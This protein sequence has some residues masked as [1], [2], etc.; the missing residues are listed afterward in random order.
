MVFRAAL[1]VRQ[2]RVNKC[3]LDWEASRVTFRQ[4][5]RIRLERLS[6]SQIESIAIEALKSLFTTRAWTV[7]NKKGTLD[8]SQNLI[9]TPLGDFKQFSEEF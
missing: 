7:Q 2:K 9:T 3:T 5:P 1:A 4:V 8:F 6:K